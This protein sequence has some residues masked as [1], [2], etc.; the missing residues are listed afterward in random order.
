MSDYHHIV[1]VEGAIQK[2]GRLLMVT[3]SEKED[4]AAGLLSFVGGK[5]EFETSAD[6][7]I[8]LTLKREIM[9]E[10]GVAVD[11]LRYVTSTGFTADDGETVVN[12]VY[13]CDWVSGEPRIV[14]P[15]EVGSVQWMT[16]EAIRQ[17]EKTPPWLQGYLHQVE[18]IMRK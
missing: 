18:L 15:D 5:V 14:D 6:D 11:N 16:I 2:E 9:E 1:N 8:S 17:H 4:H 7:P 12:L 10:V 3:R 13:L